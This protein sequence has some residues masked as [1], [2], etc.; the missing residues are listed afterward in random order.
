MLGRPDEKLRGEAADGAVLDLQVGIGKSAAKVVGHRLAPLLLGD[1]L[2]VE[3]NAHV[4]AM[5]RGAG[6]QQGH[7]ALN[8]QSLG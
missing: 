8:A 2:P 4:V 6:S 7:R 5:P 3:Q 1:G